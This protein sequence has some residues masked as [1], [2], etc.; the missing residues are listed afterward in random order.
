[1]VCGR[2][3]NQYH[4]WNGGGGKMKNLFLVLIALIFFI[5]CATSYQK[6]GFSGGFSETQLSE[7]IW[8]VHFNG[9][10]HS[11]MERAEDF[12]LLRSAE[13]TLE[14]GYRYFAIVD[15]NS[16]TE[17]STISTPQ[18]A[19]TNIFGHTTYTGGQ[20]S[21][22][23][24]PSTQNTIVMLRDKSNNSGIVYEAQFLVQ[25]LK[26]KYSSEFKKK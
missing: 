12:C 8:K 26:E 4:L 22:L 23:H 13:L 14:N 15:K 10:A 18:Q 16:D 25:S 17:S 6:N 5:G 20:T 19:H 9:N 2:K 3:K 21:T 24:K 7:N 11:T 1:L